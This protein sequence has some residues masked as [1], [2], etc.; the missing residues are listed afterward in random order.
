MC[1]LRARGR[2]GGGGCR[3]AAA[4]P[5]G[6]EWG[7]ANLY[8]DGECDLFDVFWH[9]QPHSHRI[10]NS[11]SHT[12]LVAH[13]HALLVA[14]RHAQPHRYGLLVAF[15]HLDRKYELVDVSFSIGHPHALLVAHRHA[16]L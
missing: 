8:S 14:H 15:L 4:L 7:D 2:R 12:I 11:Q 3:R 5:I 1:V 16:Q 13:R 6:L 10:V 9:A